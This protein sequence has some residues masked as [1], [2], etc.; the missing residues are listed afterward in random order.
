MVAASERDRS[1]GKRDPG[2]QRKSREATG[3]HG[4]AAPPV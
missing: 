2:E 4:V 1:H 3:I